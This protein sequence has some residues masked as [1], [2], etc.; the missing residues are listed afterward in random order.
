MS[1]RIYYKHK[2]RIRDGKLLHDYGTYLHVAENEVF[3]C[4]IEKEQEI[5]Q[6]EFQKAI[7]R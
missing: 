6:E 7:P 4:F 1:K 3:D 2:N 5:T